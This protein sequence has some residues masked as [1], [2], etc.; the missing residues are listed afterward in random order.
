M[1]QLEVE[2]YVEMETKLEDGSAYTDLETVQN[3][4]TPL[5]LKDNTLA[6]ENV[7]L[8]YL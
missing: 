8:S 5:S 3:Y 6:D 1:K 2:D 4:E 7:H